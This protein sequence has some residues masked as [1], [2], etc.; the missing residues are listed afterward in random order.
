MHAHVLAIPGVEPG[1][2]YDWA[3]SV[4]PVLGD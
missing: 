4:A 1:R 2:A 3:I